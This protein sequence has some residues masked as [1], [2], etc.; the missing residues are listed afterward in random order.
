MLDA[1]L[2]AG[3]YLTDVLE[4]A[5]NAIICIDH[6]NRVVLMNAAAEKLWRMD[7]REVLG[8]NVNV[9]VPEAIRSDH[10]R[11]IRHNRDTGDDRI[12]GTSRD[13]EL[14]RGDGTTVWVNLSLSKARDGQG[15]WCYTAFL[16][17]VSRMREAVATAAA[18][19]EAVGRATEE[20]GT[21]GRT[22]RELSDRTNL[23][24]I[25]ASVEA[26]R[27]GEHGRSFAVVATEVQR[28]ADRTRKA[29]AEIEAMVSENRASF[30]SIART[31]ADLRKG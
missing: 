28:L 4:T 9:L 10:D 2:Q 16:R 15:R 1:D 21:A 18:A 7:R 22:V 25:N 23:L 3:G 13:I 24:A 5:V 12:V 11:M 31:I 6:A 30:E 14:H 26:A 29:A 27:A 8:R 17:D 19:V 20:I